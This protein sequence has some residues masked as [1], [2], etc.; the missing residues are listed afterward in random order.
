MTDH[1]PESAVPRAAVSLCTLHHSA[2]AHSSF[3]LSLER[4]QLP[5]VLKARGVPEEERGGGS[6]EMAEIQGHLGPRPVGF[7]LAG[8]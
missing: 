6:A 1:D 7:V 8:V 5:A 2:H 3:D 4:L